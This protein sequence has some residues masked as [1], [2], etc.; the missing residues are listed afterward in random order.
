[1]PVARVGSHSPPERTMPMPCARLHGRSGGGGEAGADRPARR[2]GQGGWAELPLSPG[3]RR[4]AFAMSV[5]ET[6]RLMCGRLTWDPIVTNNRSAQY[7][8]TDAKTVLDS[9]APDVARFRK[10]AIAAV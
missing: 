3:P 10:N 8:E 4:G 1:M 2:P 5:L 7:D 6:P 9:S